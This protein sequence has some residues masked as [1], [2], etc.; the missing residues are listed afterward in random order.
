MRRN[1]VTKKKLNWEKLSRGL[2]ITQL[3]KYFVIK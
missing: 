1:L 2:M 3:V